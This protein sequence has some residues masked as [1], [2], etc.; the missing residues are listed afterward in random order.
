[1]GK[2][3]NKKEHIL[4]TKVDMDGNKMEESWLFYCSK[5]KAVLE[6]ILG[7]LSNFSPV[8]MNGQKNPTYIPFRSKSKELKRKPILDYDVYFNYESP[9]KKKKEED[10]IG[11]YYREDIEDHYYYIEMLDRCDRNPRF[12]S[13]EFTLLGNRNTPKRREF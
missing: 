2:N 5:S 1:M 10:C 3:P 11:I 9:D 6:P 13:G 4:V 12:A 8:L 7:E